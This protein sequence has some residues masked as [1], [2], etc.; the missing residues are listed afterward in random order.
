M[1]I[2][3]R[4]KDKRYTPLPPLDLVRRQKK[5][6]RL[7]YLP[8]SSLTKLVQFPLPT[9]HFLALPT[10]GGG[11]RNAVQ[12]VLIGGWGICPLQKLSSSSRAKKFG[13]IS[14]GDAW[15]QRFG[16]RGSDSPL[17]VDRAPL[18]VGPR[19][20]AFSLTILF[21]LTPPSPWRPT[22][23]DMYLLSWEVCRRHP[24]LTLN[25]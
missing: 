14:R 21:L 25:F 6:S 23:L 13:G 19:F 12:S 2:L 22:F 5:N 4:K 3:N 1:G 18:S 7:N 24:K 9:A 8:L 16:S 10:P 15:A 11:G 20:G 17:C